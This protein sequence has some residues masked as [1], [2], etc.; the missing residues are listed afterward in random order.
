MLEGIDLCVF[1]GQHGAPLDGVLEGLSAGIF[2]EQYGPLVLAGLELA[3]ARK[4]AN[5]PGNGNTDA[6]GHQ[7]PDKAARVTADELPDCG[8]KLFHGSKVST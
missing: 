6:H 3:L 4:S 2:A 7:L 1:V 5:E 8:K